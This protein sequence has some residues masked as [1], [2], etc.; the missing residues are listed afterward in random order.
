MSGQPVYDMVGID[1]ETTGLDSFKNEVIEI[2]AIEFN[3]SRLIGR[4][5]TQLCRPLAGCIPPEASKVNGITYDMV[6]DCL[7]YLSDKVRE[8]FA[9][10]IGDRTAV[11][12]NIIDF[13]SKFIKINFKNVKDT[14][15]MCRAKYNSGNSLKSACKRANIE[16]NDK[17][18]HRA[19]YDVI[20]CIELYWKL[21]EAEEK[22][23]VETPLFNTNESVKQ[24]YS[25]D[26]SISQNLTKVEF[27]DDINLG[28]IPT[29]KDKSFLATQTYSYSRINLFN[30]CPFKWY[31]QYIKGFKEPDKDYFQTGKIC[32]KTAE[33]AGEWCY[34]ELFKNKLIS[35]M[36]LKGIKINS[37]VL[38]TK[39]LQEYAYY[40]YEK[41]EMV[42][43]AFPESKHYAELIYAMDKCLDQNSYEKPSM[44]DLDT[45]NKLIEKAINYYKCSNPDVISEAK[46]IMNRFYV[47]KNYSLIPGD[48]V[49]TEKKMAFDKNWNSLNNFY[50]K[51]I[52]FRGIIDVISY[53]DDCVIIADYKSSRKMMT[54]KQLKEDFQT[55]VYALLIYKFLPE[56]S[57]KRL[58]IRIDYIRYGEIVEYE[59]NSIEG[60]KEIADR[61]TNW[62][63]SS[64]QNIEKEMIKTDGTAFQPI[65]NEYCHTCFLGED[66]MCPLFNKQI[67]GKLDD[68]FACSVSTIQE[69]MAAWKRIET[70]KAENERL[71]KLCKSFIKQCSD[72]V[73]IDKKAKLDFYLSKHRDFDVKKTTLLLL[74]KKIDMA[75]FI[76]H[77]SITP[78]EIQKIFDD[79]KIVLTQEELDSISTLKSKQTFDAF[80]NEEAKAKNFINP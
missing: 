39:S 65:R 25:N 54:L 48:L 73:I 11:G 76:R 80:T 57:F 64:I 75:D 16:W 22:K 1:V 49:L 2:T 32:H 44:P 37:E 58:I 45:Y 21:T 62:I 28:I 59:I 9:E 14:L 38:N 51:D 47:T 26:A 24:L 31:M 66:G 52:F 55:M 60:I 19:S 7:S 69:C 4:T 53:F 23:K 40:I 13:D 77:Y 50:S 78:A 71:S 8:K 6:K 79:K 56:G 36:S 29:E 43:I 41:P 70:N 30:Q 27:C 3:S 15:Q 17:E 63:Y 33:W 20:K 34:K 61:A 72:P 46:N 18:S 5:M 35:Y 10:F 68:P 67:S 12:H 74:N 42:C